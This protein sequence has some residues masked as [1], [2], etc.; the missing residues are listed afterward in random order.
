MTATAQPT[1]T[2]V[3]SPDGVE[4]ATRQSGP[5]DGPAVVLLHGITMTGDFV[6][7]GSTE[8]QRHGFRVITHDARGHGRSSAPA[9]PR[10]YGYAHLTA[11]LL[12]VLDACEVDRALLVGSSMGS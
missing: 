4:L 11:D 6:L 12:A 10:A 8:L 2:M 1:E 7:M 9:D 5:A 3:I